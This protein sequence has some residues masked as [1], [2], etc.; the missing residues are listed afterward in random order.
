MDRRV[1]VLATLLASFLLAGCHGGSGQSLE[2]RFHDLT[3]AYKKTY[4]EFQRHCRNARPGAQLASAIERDPRPQFAAEILQL[5]RE[6]PSSPTAEKAAIWVICN[7]ASEDTNN[8][9]HAVNIVK[10]RYVKSR[11]LGDAVGVLKFSDDKDS[12]ALLE[13]ICADNPDKNV[14]NLARLALSGRIEESQ[15]EE[16]KQLLRAI[17]K[18]WPPDKFPDADIA[19]VAASDLY[20]L[21]HLAIGMAAPPIAGEDC[22][23]KKLKLSDYKG[24]V[25]LISFFGDW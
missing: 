18:D 20:D 19:R 22:N 7:S 8:R 15:P 23:G 14:R 10:E 21:E 24:K 17:L 2:D 16:A 1:R 12:L 3:G 25:V 9:R 6:N 13:A 11:K 5:A 4:R